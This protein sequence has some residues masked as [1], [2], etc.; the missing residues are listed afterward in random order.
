MASPSL[1]TGSGRKARTEPVLPLREGVWPAP[2][3]GFGDP[4][5]VRP[6]A[7][8]D[9]SGSLVRVE[10]ARL[11][12]SGPWKAVGL[13]LKGENDALFELFLSA[14]DGRE[15]VIATIAEEEAIA[16]WRSLGRATGLPLIMQAPNG[17]IV[18]PY[19]QI[20]RVALGSCRIRRQYGFLRQRRPRFLTR[21]KRGVASLGGEPLRAAVLSDGAAR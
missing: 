10:R 7:L 11:M 20:G 19:P 9:L 3:H 13:R 12:R 2:Q 15:V 17:E 16:E 4:V 1:V 14:G 18:E 6:R 21:R 8:I 5:A